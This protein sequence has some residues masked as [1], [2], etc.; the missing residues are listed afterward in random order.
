MN[1]RNH[2]KIQKPVIFVNNHL[3]EN[4]LQIKH[5]AKL[6]TIVIIPVNIEVL[7]IL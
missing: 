2:M 5:F 7:A 3:K 1:I 4:I 6:E